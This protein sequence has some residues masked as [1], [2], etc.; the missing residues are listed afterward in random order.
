[1]RFAPWCETLQQKPV[2]RPLHSSSLS[3]SFRTTFMSSFV[4]TGS[5]LMTS[6]SMSTANFPFLSLSLYRLVFVRQFLYRL[7]RLSLI[8][9]LAFPRNDMVLDL[10]RWRLFVLALAFAVGGVDCTFGGRLF[11][12][13]GGW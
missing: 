2:L 5:A 1:M 11:A 6:P 13:S 4:S 10:T 7:H 12:S 3:D 9:A 8:L